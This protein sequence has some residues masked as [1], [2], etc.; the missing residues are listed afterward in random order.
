MALCH[1]YGDCKT[2]SIL[3]SNSAACLYEMN[4]F[5]ASLKYSSIAIRIDPS[6]DKA[7]TRK[8]N[9]LLEKKVFGEIPALLMVLHSKICSEYLTRINAKYSVYL[10]NS[11]GMYNWK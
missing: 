8:I 5:E 6:Y 11:L 4:L 9:S 3:Y 2:R 10:A 7:Y 1:D